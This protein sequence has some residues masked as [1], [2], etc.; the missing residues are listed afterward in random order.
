MLS[1]IQGGRLDAALTGGADAPIALGSLKGFVLMKILTG[2]LECGTGRGSRPFNGDR[3]GFVLARVMH[4]VIVEELEHAR[5]R[6]AK[7]YAEIAGYGSTCEA[8]HRVRMLECGEE[9]ARAIELAMREGA[10]HLPT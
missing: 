9:S 2:Q 5:R 8:F 4:G 10:S 1:E 6:G 7:I 3:D